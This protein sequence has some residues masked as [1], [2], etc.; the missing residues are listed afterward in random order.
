MR[1]ISSKIPKAPKMQASNSGADKILDILKNSDGVTIQEIANQASINRITAAKYLAVMEAKDIV[2]FRR[3]G[4]A[5]LYS[6]KS[7]YGS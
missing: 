6:V 2:K 7:G 4:K 5:K 1:I 3:V